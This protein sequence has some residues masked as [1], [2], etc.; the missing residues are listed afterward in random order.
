MRPVLSDE[1]RAGRRALEGMPGVQLLEDWIWDTNAKAWV[2]KVQLSPTFDRRDILPAATAW[3]LLADLV[4]PRGKIKFQPANLGGITQTFQHQ[5][6]NGSQGQNVPWRSGALCLETSVRMLN[7]HAYDSEPHTPDERLRWHVE[8]ALAWLIAATED[9]LVRSG[10]PFEL[11]QF[12]IV[13]GDTST[14]VFAEGVDTF[15]TW[16][17]IDEPCGLVDLVSIKPNL[18]L[19][20][21]FRSTSGRVLVEPH[22]GQAIVAN[23]APT[24][25]G[26]W[27]R[28][29]NVPV[30][31]PWQAP[32]TWQELRGVLQAQGISID[33]LLK[34]TFRHLRDGKQH[35]ALIG[36]PVAATV[37]AAP[38]QMHWQPLRLPVLS[39]GNMTHA[40]FRPNDLGY[41]VND[42]RMLLHN[43][44]IQWVACENWHGNE[45]STRGRVSESLRSKTVAIIG[46][47]ALGSVVAELL[48]RTGVHNLVLIDGDIFK[49]GNLGRHILTLDDLLK[50]KASALAHRLNRVS[51]HAS[52][53]AVD[54]HFPPSDP[55]HISQIQ[56]ADIVIDCS[57]NDDLLHDLEAFAWDTPRM[58][59]SYSLGLQ[60]QR[61][62]CF[63]AQAAMFPRQMFLDAV[64]PFLLKEWPLYAEQELPREGVGC[65]HP[66]FPARFDD[67]AMMAGHAVKWLEEREA[68]PPAQP[69][70]TVYRQQHEAGLFVGVRQ[71]Q[72][73]ELY[74]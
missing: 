19:V 22:W 57:A 58:F 43:T 53:K 42:R 11:P 66:V 16:S 13:P 47:G 14:V 71:E 45:L 3:Y 67:I 50:P 23:K 41:W 31:P 9:E 48:M 62:F 63:T 46:I 38:M 12:P 36:F 60:A 30:L 4:Y 74:A 65:W 8:R 51:P 7:R 32:A 37:G 20:Q 21:R 55:M 49:A 25:R 64:Q 17:T 59:V 61:L 56:G 10:D 28:V 34:S 39:R 15:A 73:E 35:V 68:L 70:L 44:A 24:L 40:G 33:K 29:D 69:S 54:H 2:L 27:F 26:M 52:V 5:A 18:Y 1:L 72:V 6:Y